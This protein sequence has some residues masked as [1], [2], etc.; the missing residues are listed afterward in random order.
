[1]TALYSPA[2]SGRGLPRYRIH[3]G[4]VTGVVSVLPV[5]CCTSGLCCIVLLWCRIRGTSVVFRSK[6]CSDLLEDDDWASLFSQME[7]QAKFLEDVSCDVLKASASAMASS[8]SAHRHVYLRDWKVDAA[9]KSGLFH[10]P[11]SGS[12]LF[13]DDLEPMLHK[14]SKN[15]KHGQLFRSRFRIEEGSFTETFL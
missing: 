3:P 5:E 7:T 1:M 10:G 4:A 11:F 8:V 2:G 14:A 12:R 15:Q 6:R 13:G 9:Q